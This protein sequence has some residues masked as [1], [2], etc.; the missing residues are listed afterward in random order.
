MA[1]QEHVLF[2]AV[3]ASVRYAWWPVSGQGFSTV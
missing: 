1:A 3:D 2:A